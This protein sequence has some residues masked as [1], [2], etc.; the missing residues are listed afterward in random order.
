MNSSMKTDKLR[1]Y[2]YIF[3]N[4]SGK[5][6]KINPDI[7]ARTPWLRYSPS[8]D[9]PYCCYSL[10]FITHD[11]SSHTRDWSNIS[12]LVKKHVCEKSADHTAVARGEAF[13]CTQ[14][15]GAPNICQE[16][17]S[18][19]AEQ[20]RRNRIILK[21][22]TEVLVMMGKENI[23]IRGHQDEDGNFMAM[24]SLFAKE[25]SVLRDHL[26]NAP[27]ISN[28]HVRI[29]RTTS[30]FFSA[31]QI[32][33][34]IIDNCRRSVIYALIADESTDVTNKEQISICIRFVGRKEDGKHLIREEFLTFVHADKGINAEDSQQNL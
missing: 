1:P 13:L 24:L 19:R 21:C 29:S 18:Q 12:K 2:L 11:R 3:R 7:I 16:L 15:G 28:I 20:A 6:R 17:H 22:I 32:F 9:T 4:I 8:T 10:L 33:D 14:R 31:K 25:N 5:N 30:Y 27:R 26:E 34:G 23:A